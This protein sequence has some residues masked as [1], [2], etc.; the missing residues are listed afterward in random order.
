MSHA[1]KYWLNSM[2]EGTRKII[3]TV[4]LVA[5]EIGPMLIRT[6]KFL[7]ELFQEFNI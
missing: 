2:D 5:V 3:V 4:A 7:K 6:K 1:R